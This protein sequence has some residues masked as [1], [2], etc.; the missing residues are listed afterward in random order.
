[1]ELRLTDDQRRELGRTAGIE[2]PILAASPTEIAAMALAADACLRGLPLALPATAMLHLTEHQQAELKSASGVV[3]EALAFTPRPRFREA[4]SD[5]D[6]PVE[7][8]D[9]RF[10]VCASGSK[11]AGLPGVDLIK[12]SMDAPQT[13]AFG[14]GRHPSTR[15]A[16]D[17]LASLAPSLGRVVDIGTGSGILAIAALLLGAT[18]VAAVDTDPDALRLAKRNVALNGFEG[19]VRLSQGDVTSAANP[20]FDV[21]IANL[22][23]AILVEMAP[24]LAMSIRTGGHVIVSGVV[25]ERMGEVAGELEAVGFETV[26]ERQEATWVARTMRL[27]AP[28]IADP[29][30]VAWVSSAVPPRGATGRRR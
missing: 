13:T 28:A 30:S 16:A 15:L 3:A 20:P 8:A 24:T 18:T 7:L 29:H 17:L 26:N 1:M 19:R 22:F 4:W 25:A 5:Q 2:M 23:P 14:T 9:G 21:A 6:D 27:A 12:L 10:L 11:V